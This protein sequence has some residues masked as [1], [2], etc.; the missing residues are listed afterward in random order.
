MYLFFLTAVILDVKRIFKDG[1]VIFEST[2][3]VSTLR[4][5][6]G[7]AENFL[8]FITCAS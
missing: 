7:G 3:S 8:P 2:D 4:R 6:S 5:K 1:Y